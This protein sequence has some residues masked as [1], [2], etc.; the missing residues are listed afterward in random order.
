MDAVFEKFDA[1]Y[2]N[3]KGPDDKFGHAYILEDICD[4]LL[5]N[6]NFPEFRKR[7]N[8]IRPRNA[9]RFLNIMERYYTPYNPKRETENDVIC[10][11]M[12]QTL[13]EDMKQW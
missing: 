6:D 9:E 10:R 11:A 2:D 3:D 4:T 7:F 5:L 1:I 13:R 8:K 12:I